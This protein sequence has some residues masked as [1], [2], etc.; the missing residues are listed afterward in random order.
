MPKKLLSDIVFKEISPPDYKQNLDAKE[1]AEVLVRRLGLKRKESRA[2][3]AR[4][5]L[6]M[7]RLKRENIP[8]NIETMAQWL[9]VSVS[10]TYEEIRKWRTLSLIEFVKVP[11]GVKKPLG[12]EYQKGYMLTAT[13]INRLI[14]RV[15][16]S[17]GSFLRK[18]KRI[19][20]DFDDQ[21]ML[22]FVR[23]EKG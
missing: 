4:L 15:S 3:H 11:T 7:L 8:C 18:T 10:Q 5:L 16:S 14:D 9:G 2:D 22:E 12:E 13:T 19:A 23:K 6:E 20:K 21:F 17:V 1:L